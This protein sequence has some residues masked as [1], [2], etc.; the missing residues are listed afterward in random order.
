LIESASSSADLEKYRLVF[1]HNPERK[2]QGWQEIR[3]CNQYSQTLV[4]VADPACKDSSRYFFGAP[5]R[6]PFLLNEAATLPKDFV[7]QA[8]AWH[9]EQ[10]R[11]AE[12]Q[13]RIAQERFQCWQAENPE[14]DEKALILEA[15]N[16]ISPDCDYSEWVSIGMTLFA[17]FGTEGISIWDGWSAG[18]TKH[19][20]GECDRKAKSFTNVE[21]RIGHLINLAK[22][23]GFRF[24]GK[25]VGRSPS[26][27]GNSPVN[28][29]CNSDIWIPESCKILM[30]LPYKWTAHQS[31]L[32]FLKAVPA[33]WAKPEAV[34]SRDLKKHR[35]A[36][37]GLCGLHLPKQDFQETLLV[38]LN[39]TVEDQSTGS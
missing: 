22:A 6:S 38:E 15:L 36:W 14:K 23:G 21:P 31:L 9:Q 37:L 2:P 24:P 28:S 10:K 34:A 32:D 4:D 13:A 33:V 5:G 20:P 7:E 1:R 16:Y 30:E 19:K 29:G 12:E 35:E 39:Q 3:A 17:L 18:S 26:L 11:K 27:V 8:L 25:G